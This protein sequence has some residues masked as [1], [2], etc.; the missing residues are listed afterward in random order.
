MYRTPSIIP[1][2]ANTGALRLR[3]VHFGKDAYGTFIA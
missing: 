2:I 1:N 3:C